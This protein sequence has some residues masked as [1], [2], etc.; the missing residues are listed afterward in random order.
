MDEFEIAC[1]HDLLGGDV[2]TGSPD[3][4]P[5]TGSFVGQEGLAAPEQA[6]PEPVIAEPAIDKGPLPPPPAPGPVLTRTGFE[7]G[8]FVHYLDK[9]SQENQR[10]LWAEAE[11]D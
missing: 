3:A 6:A 11:A 2:M 10:R 1:V 7:K 5:G 9:M 4:M 8:N